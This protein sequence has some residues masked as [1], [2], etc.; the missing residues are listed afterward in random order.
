MLNKL[1]QHPLTRGM[2]L[3]D[4]KTTALRKTIIKEKAFLKQ[5]YEEW[6]CI[7]SQYL[8]SK[9]GFSLEIGT[10]AGFLNNYVSNLITS[11]I[12][13]V[14]G[15]DI[16]FDAHHLPFRENSFQTIFLFNVLH[17]IR[18]PE[19]F[20]QEVE[21]S[22]LKNGK[23]IMIEPWVSPWSKIIYNKLHHE[24]FN[25]DIQTWDLPESGPLS[26]GND[27]LPW[28]IF[29][30]DRKLFEQKV[31]LKIDSIQEIMPFR[32]LLSGGI[33]TR[34]LMPGWMFRPLTHLE[35]L[36]SKKSLKKLA[37]FALIVLKKNDK[38]NNCTKIESFLHSV[39][40]S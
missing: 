19:V 24:P 9:N 2:D 11:D 25:T 3:D 34:N 7:S 29:H 12:L 23:L 21:H 30:R 39:H 4:P 5:I 13:P 8:P 33:S 6:Y 17:H 10:G 31:S 38:I 16:V 32:Y 37:M 40:K 28:I 22:L 36:I 27:A 35:G 14:Q 1:L 15:I 18:D 26:G 20:F